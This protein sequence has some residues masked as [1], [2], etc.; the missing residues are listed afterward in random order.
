[1]NP[2]LDVE[3]AERA[4]HRLESAAKEAIQAADRIEEA[5]RQFRFLT[6]SG[7]GNNVERFIEVATAI[8]KVN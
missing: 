8:N 4:A 1:M 7:Y 6:D 2:Y 3:G 5:I